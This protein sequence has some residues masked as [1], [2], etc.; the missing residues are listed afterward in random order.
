MRIEILIRIAKGA[1]INRK[2]EK[3]MSVMSGSHMKKVSQ[4]RW[5]GQLGH[6]ADMTGEAF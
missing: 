5:T 3:E 4:G 2:K 6:A 1:L